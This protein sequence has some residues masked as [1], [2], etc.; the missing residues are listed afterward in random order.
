MFIIGDISI[1]GAGR[2][3]RLRLCAGQFVVEIRK[4]LAAAEAEFN[5]LVGAGMGSKPFGTK[6]AVIFAFR[7]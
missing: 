1:G 3:L 5:L 6:A 4:C 2:D 7:E